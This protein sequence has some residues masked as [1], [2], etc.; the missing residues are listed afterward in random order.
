MSGRLTA[1]RGDVAR[2][3]LSGL[4]VTGMSSVRYLTGFT[5]SSGYLLVEPTGAILFT[6]FRYREQAGV[7]LTGEV[8][9][10]VDT[11]GS[12]SALSDHL[13]ASPPGRRIGFESA[14][15][16]V[17][18][19]ERLAAA[20]DSVIWEPT[21]GLVEA[22]RAVK[23]PAEVEAIAA[24]VDLAD[25]VLEGF[26][27]EIRPGTTE[28]RLAARLE[29]RLREAGSGPLPFDPIVAFGERSALPHATPSDRA[30][31]AG[32]LVLLDFGARV[33][34]YCSDMTRV[35][36]MGAASAWQR[37]LHG[38]VLAA[39]EAALSV[40]TAGAG[41]A[42][43]DAAARNSLGSAGLA[44]EFGHSTGHGLGIDVH[45]APRLHRR[46]TGELEA[47]NVV[48][49]EPGVYLPGQGGIRI[50]QVVV[51]EP[52]GGRVLTHSSPELIEL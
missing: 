11:D 41:C 12:W 3:R 16:S 21:E 32:D 49:I 19:H 4:L 26:L 46:E 47:G 24:A 28:S 33:D 31:G 23:E 1:L 42:D 14:R 6:D 35:F 48:T 15:L 8:G 38:A 29:Y 30:L 34:G 25:L 9:L 50:E 10:H 45:E 43:V 18:E 17:A 2:A 52:D 44:E 27:G 5:G 7:E 13:G 22:H 36:S 40:T 39:V 51:V 37:D 20:C